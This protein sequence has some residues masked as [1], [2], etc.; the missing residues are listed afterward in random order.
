VDI[1][2]TRTG[3]TVSTFVK[4]SKAQELSV[5]E[6]TA[7]EEAV[8]GEAAF[9]EAAAGESARR[10]PGT[11]VGLALLWQPVDAKQTTAMNQ[12]LLIN[13]SI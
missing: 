11:G 6:E 7:T 8:V 4:G 13:L 5:V 1:P 9:E 3:F 10:D 2:G 12:S